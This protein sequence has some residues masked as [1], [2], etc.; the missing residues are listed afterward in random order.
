MVRKIVAIIGVIFIGALC[1]GIF[2]IIKNP[3]K[4]QM[5]EE[6]IPVVFDCSKFSRISADELR[7]ELGEPKTTE[8]W[9]N[10][11]SKG[12]F[13]MQIFTY[14]LEGVYGEFI[15]YEDT[16]VKLHLFSD[17]QWEI[18]G[19]S[20]DNIFAMFGIVPGKNIKRTVNTGVT[21]KFSPVSDKVAEIEVYNYDRE[22]KSFDTVYVT[23]DLSYFD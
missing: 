7:D 16:V 23:Y 3:E 4:Y 18:T 17:S 1:F 11:T 2:Q 12:N 15:L 8:D 10:R 6:E 9:M 21:H 5:Q 14:D 22:N 19:S 20:F 13:Q